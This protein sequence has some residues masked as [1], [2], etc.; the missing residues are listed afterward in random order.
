M[1]I[2]GIITL[3]NKSVQHVMFNNSFYKTKK[4]IYLLFTTLHVISKEHKY[5]SFLPYL[6]GI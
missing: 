6:A 3:K 5:I 4:N 1:T 2:I